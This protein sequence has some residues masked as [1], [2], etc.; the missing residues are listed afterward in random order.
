MQAQSPQI[1]EILLQR[2]AGPYVGV[3]ALGV[4]SNQCRNWL[5]SG[6]HPPGWQGNKVTPSRCVLFD[7]DRTSPND[8]AA[9]CAAD[10]KF[11]KSNC[12]HLP[13]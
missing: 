12:L 10:L 11:F 9:R 5:E 4:G 1:D 7:R 6:R 13:D 3:N 2:T 8:L